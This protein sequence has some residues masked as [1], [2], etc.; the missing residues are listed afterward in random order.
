[1]TMRCS[2]RIYA[3]FLVNRSVKAEASMAMMKWKVAGSMSGVQNCRSQR[4]LHV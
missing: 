3:I 1:M 2:S 4:S